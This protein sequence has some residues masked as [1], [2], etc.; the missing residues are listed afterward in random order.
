MS[1]KKQSAKD[2]QIAKME[3]EIRYLRGL[4][5]DLTAKLNNPVQPFTPFTRD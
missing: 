4:V 5:L 2:E 1:K 3:E